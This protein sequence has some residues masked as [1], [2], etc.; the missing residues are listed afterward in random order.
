MSTVIWLARGIVEASGE[1]EILTCILPVELRRGCQAATMLLPDAIRMAARKATARDCLDSTEC[2]IPLFGDSG[3]V[4]AVGR[5]FQRALTLA[6]LCDHARGV[7]LNKQ[8]E[9]FRCPLCKSWDAPPRRDSDGEY[10]PKMCSTCS[11]EYR[12]DRKTQPRVIVSENQQRGANWQPY[13]DGDSIRRYEA[14]H[15]R[16]IDL[17]AEGINYKSPECYRSPKILIRQ[18]G[19]GVSAILDTRGA[20]CPQSVYMYH[21]KESFRRSGIGEDVV[22][23]LICS[24]LFHLQ[25]FMCF[26]EIDSSRAFAKLTHARLSGLRILDPTRL[27]S[28]GALLQRIKKAIVLLGNVGVAEGREHDWDIEA[29]WS[30]ILGLSKADVEAVVRNFSHIHENEVLLSLFPEGVAGHEADW[31]RTWV[32]AAAR[33]GVNL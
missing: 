28:V 20:Y 33:C 7:E 5:A 9:I 13:I 26:G 11:R 4:T 27:S 23:S 29:C 14:A 8:G 16:F 1:Y 17:S 3:A 21:V 15:Y 19:I 25:V 30:G 10:E 12:I 22:L 18:A 2:S 24:R 32:D 6:D 31:V